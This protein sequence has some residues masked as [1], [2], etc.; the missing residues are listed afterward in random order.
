MD[1]SN[2]SIDTMQISRKYENAEKLGKKY[3]IFEFT[4]LVKIQG[5]SR[6]KS[7]KFVQYFI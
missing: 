4:L 6:F 2:I 7:A 1:I 5:R 3:I